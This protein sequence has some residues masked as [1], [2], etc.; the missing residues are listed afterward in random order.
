MVSFDTLRIKVG[1]R[2]INVV[3]VDLDTCS[4]VY[5]TAPCTAAVGTTGSQK[6]FNTFKTCQD[7]ANYNKAVKTYR[8]TDQTSFLPVGDTVY[9]CITNVD[10]ASTQLKPDS[11]AV[12]GTATISFQD[13]PHH[14]RGTDP[15]YADREAGAFERGTF[16]SK[17][18]ARS[19]YIVNRVVRINSGYID[20][21]RVIFTR[22][23]TYFVDRLEGPDA[24]G[25]V[26]LICKDVLRFA[27][28]EKAKVP[29]ASRG[30]L[31]AGI[32]VGAT[33]L[34]LTPSGIGSEYAATSDPS[35]LKWLRIGDELVTYTTRTG[36]TISGISRAQAGTVAKAY[37]AGDAVQRVAFF[38]NA[39]VADAAY[40][41]L[42]EYASVPAAY[43]TKSE[44]DSEVAAWLAG[45]T[46]NGVY[47]SEPNGVKEELEKLLQSAGT[48]LWWDD[49]SAKLRLKVLVPTAIGGTVP[50]MNEEANIL[51]GSL[52][53]RDLEKE[54]VSRVVVYHGAIDKV[55]SV[56]KDNSA[57]VT[58]SLDA[59]T[60]SPNAYGTEQNKEIVSRWV[61]TA[62]LATELGNRI[63]VRYKNTPREFIFK[64]DAKD[65]TLKVG[66][67]VDVY[68]RVNVNPD[69]AQSGARCMITEK[70]EVETGSHYEYVSLTVTSEAVS[71]AYLITPDGHPDWLAS[72]AA[73]KE[74]YFYISGNN[75]LMSDLAAGATLV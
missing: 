16:F 59:A 72:S 45:Y 49:E 17:L 30:A 8:F 44:W 37:S 42:T 23:R 66:D 22:A 46:I 41:L 32:A 74:K 70:R 13:F 54:R 24:N 28:V 43:I 75:G 50:I 38:N 7:S 34:T 1:R 12:S 55:G 19:P 20:D 60:E 40:S 26:Q 68:C 67:L 64:V 35:A 61:P 15:Y 9:P 21:N 69:G 2:P 10:I 4:R 25:R 56:S 63:L 11:L 51:Q 18:R 3:E 29:K 65:A 31:S 14:D 47:L 5:G 39:T 27:D 71:K 57:N 6:C 62:T 73:Q 53:V 48:A 52:R 33:S 58:I 36:D